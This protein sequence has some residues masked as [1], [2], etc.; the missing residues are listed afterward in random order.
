MSEI[1]CPY[2]GDL[3]ESDVFNEETDLDILTEW[4]CE[5]CQTQFVIST[6]PSKDHRLGASLDDLVDQEDD[7]HD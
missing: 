2:C 7:V 5:C 4:K 3:I 1:Y 6:V